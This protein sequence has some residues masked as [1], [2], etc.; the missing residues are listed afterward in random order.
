[1]N[2]TQDQLIHIYIIQLTDKP[3]SHTSPDQ[4]SATKVT[5]TPICH[6]PNYTIK[7]TETR[8]T[9]KLNYPSQQ[10]VLSSYEHCN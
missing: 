4:I 10:F 5:P 8:E 2:L 9:L 3:A 1:M 7:E 6:K